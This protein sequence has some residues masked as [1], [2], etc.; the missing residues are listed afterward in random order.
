MVW[1]ALL[2][3]GN[4]D[5]VCI[6][7]DILKEVLPLTDGESAIRRRKWYDTKTQRREEEEEDVKEKRRVI[8]RVDVRSTS[9][10][11]S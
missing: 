1:R 8:K 2:R 10:R 11:H 7:M 6:H 5:I 9:T 3:E 4:D